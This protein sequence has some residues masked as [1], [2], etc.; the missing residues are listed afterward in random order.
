VAAGK[1]G[2]DYKY[3]ER[4]SE[5]FGYHRYRNHRVCSSPPDSDKLENLRALKERI[6]IDTAELS[7]P[8]AVSAFRAGAAVSISWAFNRATAKEMIQEFNENKENANR[9]RLQIDDVFKFL[10]TEIDRTQ[11]R[12]SATK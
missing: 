3:L 5:V 11:A 2:I 1:F 10:D 8:F 6:K 9:L 12:L 4:D 7:K